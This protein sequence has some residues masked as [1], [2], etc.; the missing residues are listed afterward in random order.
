MNNVHFSSDRS[1]AP[2]SLAAWVGCVADL[3]SCLEALEPLARSLGVPDPTDAEWH[4]ALFGKL[5][6]QIDRGPL[7][8]AAVCG[9]TNTG[10]SL[11]AN[12]LVGSEISRSVPEAARTRHPVVS[13][14]RGLA[15]RIDL[16]TLFPGFTPRPWSGEDDALDPTEANV[17]VWR[18]D[19]GGEQPQLLVLLDTPRHRRHA[20]L[21]LAAG[22]TDPQR[23]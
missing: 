23:L 10:K 20:P 19:A 5:K 4:G 9:G 21:Q 18:E 16:A 14:P 2:A 1:A 3:C 6:P 11:I 12:A 17:L 22:G 8:V 7:L 13:L 15:G